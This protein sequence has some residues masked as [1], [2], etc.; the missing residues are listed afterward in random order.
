[1]SRLVNYATD[2]AGPKAREF[3]KTKIDKMFW[4]NVIEPV[5]SKW[6]LTFSFASKKDRSLRSWIGY[7]KL[8]VVTVKKAYL[9]TKIDDCLGFLS[10]AC[11]LSTLY[12]ES[13]YWHIK[14]DD[15]DKYKTTFTKHHGL[16]RI[17]WMLLGL[18]KAPSTLQGLMHVILP[19]VKWQFALV[20]LAKVVIFSRYVEE[21]LDHMW[22]VLGRLL[23]AGMALDR[24]LAS[25]LS[26]VSII[27]FFLY[28]MAD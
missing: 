27:H 14:I 28:S 25:S 13:G 4:K 26:T 5:Q 15:L 1:M 6:A 21:H 23:R 9:I 2:H 10:K 12:V 16:Q 24:R 11:M 19:A 7:R 20:Y 18:K 22:T 3:E 8:N 17:L